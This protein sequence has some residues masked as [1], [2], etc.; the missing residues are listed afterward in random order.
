MIPVHR[1]TSCLLTIKRMKER[2]SRWFL[3]DGSL[4]LA[5]FLVLSLPLAFIRNGAPDKEDNRNCRLF[6]VGDTFIVAT[7][8]LDTGPFVR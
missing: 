7:N 1:K 2:H 4:S 6:C 8:R 5:L 3:E